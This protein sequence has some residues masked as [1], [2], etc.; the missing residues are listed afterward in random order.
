[1]KYA[2]QCMMR[3]DTEKDRNDVYAALAPLLA[4][5]YNSDDCY[6]S[7]HTCHHD[8]D[9][10]KPCEDVEHCEVSPYRP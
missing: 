7:R 6:L 10:V 9:P 2:I 3:F 4:Q 1:M 5:R 8:E